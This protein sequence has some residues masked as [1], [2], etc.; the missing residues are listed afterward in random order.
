MYS[1]RAILALTQSYAARDLLCVRSS[2]VI[3]AIL[4]RTGATVA[5]RRTA[6]NRDRPYAIARR[7]CGGA[8][9]SH[10]DGAHR[11]AKNEGSGFRARAI[12]VPERPPA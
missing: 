7:A 6:V 8:R 12:R 2:V 5:A 4:V 10:A 3:E 1:R 11:L 9:S